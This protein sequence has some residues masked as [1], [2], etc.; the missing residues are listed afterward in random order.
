MLIGTASA[1][2]QMLRRFLELHSETREHN[3]QAV[4]QL[5][6]LRSEDLA[7][8][9]TA[10]RLFLSLHGIDELDELERPLCHGSYSRRAG[11]RDV[12]RRQRQMLS[13]LQPPTLRG[14]HTIGAPT[15]LHFNGNGKRHQWRCVHEFRLSGIL[16]G[17]SFKLASC[18]FFNFD[19]GGYGFMG[20]KF[21][22]DERVAKLPEEV[23]KER[24][25]A[26][27][28]VWRDA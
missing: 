6:L 8:V 7:L 9:D 20:K 26:V 24:L 15:G 10:G 1:L 16:A 2:S 13:G 4:M 19:R 17:P 5:L 3:D 25:R 23:Q 12:S 28:R 21:L 22:E 11:F 14:D 18:W 27:R